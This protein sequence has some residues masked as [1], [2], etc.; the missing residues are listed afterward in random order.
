MLED[1]KVSTY[2]DI[3]ANLLLSLKSRNW[4]YW[5]QVRRNKSLTMQV[6]ILQLLAL[7]AAGVVKPG[8]LN[9]L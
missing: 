2:N 9:S 8:Q 6:Q 3:P 4:S 5:E 7:Q 1:G